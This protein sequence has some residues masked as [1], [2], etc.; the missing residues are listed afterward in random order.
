MA[1]V[2]MNVSFFQVAGN[3]CCF[4]IALIEKIKFKLAL[5]Y[6]VV[7]PLFWPPQDKVS[8]TNSFTQVAYT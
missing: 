4:A 7:L 6:Y 1:L 3:I 8:Y 5:N 2:K